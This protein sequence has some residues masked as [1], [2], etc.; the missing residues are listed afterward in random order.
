MGQRRISCRHG[1]ILQRLLLSS[2]SLSLQFF[3]LSCSLHQASHGFI[4]QHPWAKQVRAF[5]NLEA[6]GVGGKEVVFQTG[7]EHLLCLQIGDC[8]HVFCVAVLHMSYFLKVQ[9]TLGWSRPTSTQPNTP[10]PPWWGR[11]SFRVAS[12]PLT[13]ISAFTGTLA[14][15]QVMLHAAQSCNVW[16]LSVLITQSS[17]GLMCLCFKKSVLFFQELTWR[18]SKTV[19]S[20]IPSTTLLTGS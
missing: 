2:S 12:S 13:L 5:I 19:S 1:H 6:A 18:S 7:T 9:R 16:S 8:Q 14:T 3:Q 20:T 17:G 15:S 11:K 4:T 10:S